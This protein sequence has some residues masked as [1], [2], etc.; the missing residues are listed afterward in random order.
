VPPDHPEDDVEEFIN[1]HLG[2]MSLEVPLMILQDLEFN[3]AGQSVS[4]AVLDTLKTDKFQQ[5]ARWLLTLKNPEGLNRKELQQ[6]QKRAQR[7]CIIQDT[8]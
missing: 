4:T 1:Q 5:I 2:T 7:Y 8:L 3:T 6:L